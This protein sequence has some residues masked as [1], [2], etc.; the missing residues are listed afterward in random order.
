MPQGSSLPDCTLKHS[1]EFFFKL[2]L[3]VKFCEQYI[4]E[5]EIKRERNRR[6]KREKIEK[7]KKNQRT[8][9]GF[10]RPC[11]ICDSVSKD[12]AAKMHAGKCPLFAWIFLVCRFLVDE[13]SGKNMML[14]SRRKCF[15]PTSQAHAQTLTTTGKAVGS[16]KQQLQHSD[17]SCPEPFWY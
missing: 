1:K 6:K 9:K 10:V 2:S 5:S 16:Q 17:S 4:R 11:A 13:D 7:L 8:I 14:I 3:C 15:K 12:V